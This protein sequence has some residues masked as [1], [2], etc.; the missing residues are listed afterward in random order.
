MIA[1]M[2]WLLAAAVSAQ[3][4][5]PFSQKQASILAHDFARITLAPVHWH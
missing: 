2:G 3:P 5:S 1:L 4:V